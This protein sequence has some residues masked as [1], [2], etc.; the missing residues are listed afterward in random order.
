MDGCTVLLCF[1]RTNTV[2]WHPYRQ[3]VYP[4]LVMV[5]PGAIV[6]AL[7]AG[8][9]TLCAEDLRDTWKD[10]QLHPSAFDGMSPTCACNI[11]WDPPALNVG[12]LVKAASLLPEVD[13]LAAA[14]THVYRSY[15][16]FLA[17]FLHV[18]EQQRT[19]GFNKS[20]RYLEVPG[21]SSQRLRSA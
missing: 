7:M 16:E 2:I 19:R 17:P 5:A 10:A 1:L 3:T 11:L 15:G 12:S 8:D 14:G 20:K 21:T 13:A 6:W 18:S 4:Q 9:V